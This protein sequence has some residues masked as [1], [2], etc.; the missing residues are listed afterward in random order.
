MSNDYLKNDWMVQASIIRILGNHTNFSSV[1]LYDLCNRKL[2]KIV[3]IT[4]LYRGI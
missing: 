3:T 4:G 2:K 1:S